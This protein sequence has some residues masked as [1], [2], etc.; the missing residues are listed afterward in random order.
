MSFVD[1]SRPMNN[2][3]IFNARLAG[4]M[5][6]PE[7]L[8]PLW[9]IYAGM[10]FGHK[11][12]FD[13]AMRIPDIVYVQRNIKPREREIA[14]YRAVCGANPSDVLPP[15]Y[16][17]VMATRL[18]LNFLESDH[19]PFAL[20]GLVHLGQSIEWHRPMP[21]SGWYDFGCRM[22]GPVETERGWEFIMYTDAMMNG[23]LVWHEQLKFLKPNPKKRVRTRQRNRSGDAVHFL[24]LLHLQF[25]E[26]T[27][28]RY[29][30]VSGDWNP[31]HLFP[32]LSKRFG[33]KRPIAHGMYSLARCLS[34]LQARGVSLLGKRL[35]ASFRAP[36]MLPAYTNFSLGD[37]EPD[38]AF[39]LT[40]AQKG[41]ILVEGRLRDL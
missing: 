39:A 24:P 17:H 3:P 37:R 28:R 1:E 20:A 32:V 10:L 14:A 19:F 4:R 34:L 38:K 13:P 16:P 8:A 5:I 36:V 25:A 7:R 40:D 33:F 6:E 2:M 12:E 22:E 31:I 30:R 41:R 15:I 23:E 35:D 29:A 18:Q 11:P 26:D 27:G 21:V 9:M